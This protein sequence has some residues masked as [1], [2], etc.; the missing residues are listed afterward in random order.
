M[1]IECPNCHKS[2]L[3]NLE[4]VDTEWENEAYYDECEGVCPD[5]GKK[6]RWTEKYILT[7]VFDIKPINE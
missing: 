4:V 7:D 5:C 2:Y 1:K 6:F 3:V